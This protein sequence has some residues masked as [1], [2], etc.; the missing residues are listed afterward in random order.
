M[1]EI[2]EQTRTSMKIVSL[3]LFFLNAFAFILL[4]FIY[5][6]NSL[7]FFWGGLGHFIFLGAVL[8]ADILFS[9]VVYILPQNWSQNE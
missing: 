5:G 3:S 8:V 2:T 4:I 1:T 6:K 7:N 9:V